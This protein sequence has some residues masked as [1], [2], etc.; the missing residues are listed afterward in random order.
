VP[1]LRAVL[2]T[3][4]PMLADLIRHVLTSR[5]GLSIISEIAAPE[6]AAE[7]LRDLAPDLVIIGPSTDASPLSAAVVRN[8]LPHARVLTLS[9]DLS[10]VFGPG[11][12]DVAEFTPDTLAECLRR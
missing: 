3:V 7:S 11:E 1:E 9:A 4:P 5:V 12:D 10:R 2:V 6:A 8:M